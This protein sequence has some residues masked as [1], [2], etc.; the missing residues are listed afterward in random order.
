VIVPYLRGYG[1]TTFLSADTMRNAQP[2][3]VAVD[4]IALVDA[5][6]IQKAI[7]GGFDWGG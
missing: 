7:I 3:V 1:S 4:A 6:K 5:L 2:S